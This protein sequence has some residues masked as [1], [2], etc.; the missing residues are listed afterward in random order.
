[1]VD[2]D[3]VE[4]LR[5]KGWDWD[6]IADDPKVGFHPDAS[7]HDSGRALRGLYHRQRSRIER[8]KGDG[9]NGRS[10]RK[11]DAEVTERVWTLPRIGYLLT[12]ILGIWGLLAYVAPSP[13]GIL[14]PAVPWLAIALAVAAFVLLFGLLRSSGKRWTPVF[15]TTVVYGIVL[16]IVISGVVGL[17]GYV[18]FGCPYLPP[19]STLAGLPGPGWTKASVTPWQIDGLPTVYFYGASWCP[20]CSAGSWT[21]YKALSDFGKVTGA[22]SALGY[23]SLSD[24]SPG[25]PEIILANIGF[26]SSTISFVIN[27]DTSGVDGNFPATANC[28][29]AGYVAAYSGS[30]IPFVVI[31]GQYIHAGSPII[32]PNNLASWNYASSSTSGGASTVLSEVQSEN[33]TAWQ[34][35]QAQAWWIMAFITRATGDSVTSLASEYGWSAATKSAVTGYLAQF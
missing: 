10:S 19:A 1:M 27:E 3:R 25:T 30:A 26:S 20:Y 2:W 7:V 29:E 28:F 24:V 13:I 15:R 8:G 9:G 12:P 17:T 33:G 6:R 4:Q 32:D 11:L 18:A 22:G 16:G 35:V 14:L 34:V 23:S 5:E 31:N 21:I